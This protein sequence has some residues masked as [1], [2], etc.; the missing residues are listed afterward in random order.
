MLLLFASAKG[1]GGNSFAF[2]V[3]LPLHDEPMA[4][5][6]AQLKHFWVFDTNHSNDGFGAGCEFNFGTNNSGITI[7]PKVF[8]QVDIY[9]CEIGSKKRRAG[10]YLIG[11][12]SAIDY[13]N[14][15]GNDIRLAPEGGLSLFDLITLTYGYNFPLPSKA[16][17]RIPGVFSSRLTLFVYINGKPPQRKK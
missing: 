17:T 14:S 3:G 9:M 12:A 10:L 16:E 13:S 8:A 1:Q 2:Y 11:R 6:G 7:G 5:V 15:A 4:D